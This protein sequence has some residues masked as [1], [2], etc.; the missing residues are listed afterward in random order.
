MVLIIEGKR[1]I[2][3]E[4]GL[5]RVNSREE[6]VKAAAKGERRFVDFEKRSDDLHRASFV[7]LMMCYCCLSIPT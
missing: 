1:L 7:V 3:N 6:S 4:E 5:F 2:G